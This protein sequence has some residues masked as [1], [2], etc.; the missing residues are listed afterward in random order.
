MRSLPGDFFPA[1][2][3]LTRRFKERLD[4]EGIVVP[5]P[6]RELHIPLREPERRSTPLL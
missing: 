2:L 3:E 1:R 5:V 6:Q 4:T